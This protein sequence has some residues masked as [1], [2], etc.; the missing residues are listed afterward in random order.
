ME[1]LLKNKL[2]ES[3][4]LTEP[5]TDLAHRAPGPRP[6]EKSA[7]QSIIVRFFKYSIK[8]KIIR[9]VWEGT[10]TVDG[11]R[12]GFCDHNF[13]TDVMNTRREYLPI[14][15]FLKENFTLTYQ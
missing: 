3:P 2:T 15:R 12:P 11:R 7:Q 13:A 1:N 4:S 5:D 6:A 14:K 9:A 8:E 10:I